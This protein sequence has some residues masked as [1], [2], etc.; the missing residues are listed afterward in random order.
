MTIRAS[1]ALA[2]GVALI[3]TTLA[4]NSAF[5]DDMQKVKIHLAGG[6][7]QNILQVQVDMTGIP[8]GEV[9]SRG[10]AF[11]KGR[12]T[13]GRVDVMAVTASG[14]YISGKSCSPGFVPIADILENN[15]VLTFE[16]LS[17]L[18]GNGSGVVCLNQLDPTAIPLAEVEGTWDGGTGRFANAGGTWSGRFD[19]AEPVGIATQFIAEAG[20]LEGYLTRPRDDD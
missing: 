4:M 16:D 12:G 5:A 10:L 19:F 18:Y 2:S 6:F 9:Q 20:V 17:L 11:V 3:M 15:L 7:V 1:K 8:T 13:F 14:P